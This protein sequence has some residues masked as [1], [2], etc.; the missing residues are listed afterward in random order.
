MIIRCCDSYEPCLFIYSE[1]DL[2]YTTFNNASRL[3]L[4]RHCNLLG[5]QIPFVWPEVSLD[6]G[7]NGEQFTID[8]YCLPHLPLIELR[9]IS[10]PGESYPGS[11]H[12]CRAHCETQ[13][14]PCVSAVPPEISHTTLRYRKWHWQDKSP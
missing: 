2:H 4:C 10:V 7:V 3:L 5:Q 11:T 14:L 9:T 1:Q 8:I 13:Y 12:A 6:S